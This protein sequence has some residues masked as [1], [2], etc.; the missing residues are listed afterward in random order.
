MSWAKINTMQVNSIREGLV[1]CPGLPATISE[2]F[3]INTSYIIIADAKLSA[4][5]GK[6]MSDKIK[7]VDGVQSV[8]G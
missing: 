5:D 8:L 4:L 7:K 6:E 3:G 2:D 1:S